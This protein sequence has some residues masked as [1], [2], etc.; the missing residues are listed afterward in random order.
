G[1]LVLAGRTGAQ[2]GSLHRPA[3]RA[4]RPIRGMCTD[5]GAGMPGR[6]S[7]MSA[8]GRSARCP[9]RCRDPHA[10]GRMKVLMWHVHGAW[11]TA[12]VH[13]RHEVLV[14]LTPDRGPDGRGLP[15]TYAWP[16][17]ARA[18]SPGELAQEQF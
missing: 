9:G 8:L 12:F 1:V 15:A 3:S 14:P 4:R 18:V 2:V 13:G 10:G 7:P 5:P 11:A 6:G 17:S 16:A